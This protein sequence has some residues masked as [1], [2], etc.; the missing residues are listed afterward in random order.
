M[1]KSLEDIL[2]SIRNSKKLTDDSNSSFL[3]AEE[4]IVEKKDPLQDQFHDDS[5]KEIRDA[6]SELKDI[7]EKYITIQKTEKCQIK[8]EELYSMIKPVFYNWF[9]NNH[10]DIINT[11]SSYI[12]IKDISQDLIKNVIHNTISDRVSEERINHILAQ[13]VENYHA[14]IKQTVSH[15]IENMIQDR[16]HEIIEDVIRKIMRNK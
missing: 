14:Y 10:T 12:E 11:L 16:L 3:T 5:I 15:L 13:H 2:I 6:L 4:R 9:K 7:N 1:G 8:E